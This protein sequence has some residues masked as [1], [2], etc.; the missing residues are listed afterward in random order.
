M[1]ASPSTPSA[2]STRPRSRRRGA[3]AGEDWLLY[4]ELI[5]QDRPAPRIGW[6][7]RLRHAT[8]DH[9]SDPMA[10]APDRRKQ[11]TRA[12]RRY[13]RE[14]GHRAWRTTVVRVT[15][16][17]WHGP[18]PYGYQLRHRLDTD[19]T[20]LQGRRYRLI[21]DNRRASVVP[22]IFSWYV[23][24][25]FGDD[26]IAVRP[27]TDPH[28]YPPPLDPVSGQPCRWT[29]ARVRTILTQPAYLGYAVW[30]RTRHGLPT[31]ETRWHVSDRATHPALVAPDVFQAAYR[32]RY[33]D[34]DTL[35]D[36]DFD[37][38]LDDDWDTDAE[39]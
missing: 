28:A 10:D 3:F 30:G 5:D 4:P 38:S 21:L 18:A 37:P 22:T 35:H 20:G 29:P 24:D 11:D 23:H 13:Q 12:V 36:P 33:P 27:A 6:W 19:P 2:N 32:R 16:G 31:P 25:G 17:W 39:S 26:A 8:A 14:L 9:L 15:A 7:S 1:P 34:L